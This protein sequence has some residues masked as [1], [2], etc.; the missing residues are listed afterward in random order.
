MIAMAANP[1]NV[2]G[3]APALPA[4]KADIDEGISILDTA[5]KAIDHYSE[6]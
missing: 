6:E 3:L 5:L 2:I 4:T 1:S